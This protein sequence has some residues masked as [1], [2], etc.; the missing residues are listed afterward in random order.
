MTLRNSTMRDLITKLDLVLFESALNPKNPQADYEAKKQALDKLEMDPV[1]NKDP[2]ITKAIAQ[3]RA[4]LEKEA[5]GL[6]VKET[7]VLEKAP[8]GWEGTVKAMKKHKDIDNPYAL[9]N[10][11]KNK[12]YKSHKKEGYIKAYGEGSFDDEDFRNQERN[13]GL[14]REP[15]NNFAIYINGKKWKVLPGRG[16]YADDQRERQHY[17]QL[18]D[19]CAKKS[20]TTGKKWSVHVTGEA[21]T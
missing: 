9:A 21:P 3:R 20:A 14:D 15:P 6:G 7:S 11:M 12:G 18:Q 10:Y 16:T 8:E 13:A 2:E 17:R 1:A 19:M 4:D 5:A